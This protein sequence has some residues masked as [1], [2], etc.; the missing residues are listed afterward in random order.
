MLTPARQFFGSLVGAERSAKA[1]IARL[2][3]LAAAARAAFVEAADARRAA[4]DEADALEVR[5]YE[6]ERQIASAPDAD[7]AHNIALDVVIARAKRHA[8]LGSEPGPGYQAGSIDELRFAENRAC[9]AMQDLD[10]ELRIARERLEGLERMR[11]SDL[12]QDAKQL[13]ELGATP[14]FDLRA[15]MYR[16]DGTVEVIG[17]VPFEEVA[18]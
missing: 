12:G 11:R 3:P 8:I 7:T 5:V 4:L 17:A 10:R 2:E 14:E 13:A 16:A 15:T 1:E 9:N 18:L 6:L